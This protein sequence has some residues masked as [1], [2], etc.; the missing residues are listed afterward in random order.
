MRHR[1]RHAAGRAA[2]VL[3][4]AGS[5]TA[6]RPPGITV[7]ESPEHAHRRVPG[8]ADVV[9][10]LAVLESADRSAAHVQRAVRRVETI[11]GQCDI[12]VAA[13]PVF[14]VATPPAFGPLDEAKQSQLLA[15]LPPARP[16]ALLVEHSA[17]RD[18]GY[19]YLMSAPVASRGT[20]WITREVGPA[21]LAPVLAHELGHILL[22]SAHHSDDRANLMFHTCT[23][24][25][26]AGTRP[27][28]ALTDAQCRKLRAR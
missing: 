5:A 14:R 12:T 10:P 16:A 17:D 19:S 22:D 27:G 4:L 8:E 7:V 1:I 2:L 23:V 25:N 21:C 13:G 20:A 28:T 26:V 6:G 3:L 11:F 24:S 9:Y 15:H 18:V